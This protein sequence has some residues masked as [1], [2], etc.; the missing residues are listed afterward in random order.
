[1]IYAQKELT[2]ILVEERTEDEK[3][4]MLE[5]LRSGNIVW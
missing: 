2:A 3:S 1:M 4:M 5:D